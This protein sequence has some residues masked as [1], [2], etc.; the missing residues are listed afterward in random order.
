MVERREVEKAF[1]NAVG[2]VSPEELTRST[3]WTRM[4]GAWKSKP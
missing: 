2:T 3:E 4:F 1:C